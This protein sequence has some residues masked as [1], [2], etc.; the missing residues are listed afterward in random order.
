MTEPSTGKSAAFMA[1]G[2]FLGGVVAGLLHLGFWG[3]AALTLVS[4]FL[5]VSSLSRNWQ[6]DLQHNL[7]MILGL[8]TVIPLPCGF[9][10]MILSK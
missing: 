10:G 8:S 7:A 4:S 2:G 3:F 1:G 5:A 6:A 9:V